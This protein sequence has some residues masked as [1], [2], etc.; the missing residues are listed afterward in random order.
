MIMF[1]LSHFAYTP[2]FSDKKRAY[3]YKTTT[4]ATT[5]S[6]SNESQWRYNA[7]LQPQTL[8]LLKT[9]KWGN[10]IPYTALN[11]IMSMQVFSHNR[12]QVTYLTVTQ[13]KRERD[14]A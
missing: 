4:T 12:Y 7:S 6:I 11:Q 13:R 9:I 5:H 14:I 8:G 2:S 1:S 10:N 3:Q